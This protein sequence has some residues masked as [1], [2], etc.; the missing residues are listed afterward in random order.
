MKNRNLFCNLVLA[1]FLLVSCSSLKKGLVAS[2]P[3]AGNANDLSGHLNNGVPTGIKSVPDRFNHEN[4]AYNFD[5]E[6]SFI[7]VND[8]KSLNPESALSL[9]AWYKTVSFTGIGNNSIL[10]KGYTEHQNPYYQY[11]LGVTGNNYAN[12]P[13]SFVFALSINHNYEVIVAENS[14]VPDAWY[15]VAGT[16]DG[17]TMR[18]Y[19]NGKLMKQ[20][21]ISGK[22]DQYGQSLIIGKTKNYER[23]NRSPYT[24]GTIDDIRIYQR[25]LNDKKIMKIFKLKE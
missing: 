2:Y 22:I 11:H 18:I 23:E 1:G 13:S 19:V 15:F 24:P 3:F 12:L 5:G 21:A 20:R 25:T 9:C 10:D 16:Y 14:W 6:S 17:E 7:S 8:A 4:S